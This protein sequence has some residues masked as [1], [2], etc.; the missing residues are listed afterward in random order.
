MV[1]HAPQ[2]QISCEKETLKTLIAAAVGTEFYL[3]LFGAMMLLFFFVC[4]AAAAAGKQPRGNRG[5]GRSTAQ[6]DATPL[7]VAGLLH[8]AHGEDIPGHLADEDHAGK[9]TNCGK[10]LKDSPKVSLPRQISGPK[11][12]QRGALSILPAFRTQAGGSA[13]TPRSLKAQTTDPCRSR[14][15]SCFFSAEVLANWLSG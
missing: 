14:L 5:F 11:W 13:T 3:F 7:S 1:N 15:S 9:L 8:L 6:T 4:F 2:V 10:C 12:R